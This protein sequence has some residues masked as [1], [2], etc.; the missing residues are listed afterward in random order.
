MG[1]QQL[2][3]AAAAAVLRGGPQSRHDAASEEAAEGGEEVEVGTEGGP[4]EVIHGEGACA[5]Y[6]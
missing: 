4:T 5:N 2:P 6:N 3:V 1:P